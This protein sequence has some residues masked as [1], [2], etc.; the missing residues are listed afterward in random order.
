MTRTKAIALDNGGTITTGAID[1]LAGQK[2]V[3]PEAAA[4]LRTLHDDY[5]WRIILAS[6]HSAARDPLASPPESRDRR[7]DQRRAAVLPA[8]RAQ[9]SRR[10]SSTRS[11]SLPP[12]AR[13]GRCC[14]SATT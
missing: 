8:R 14:P 5:G 10:R 2:P 4:S 3:D 7:P 11:C 1:D 12:A 13:P 6:K 9:I